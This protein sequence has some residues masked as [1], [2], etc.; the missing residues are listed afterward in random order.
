VK[1]VAKAEHPKDDVQEDEG[2]DNDSDSQIQTSS[3]LS[4]TRSSS[5]SVKQPQVEPGWTAA[6]SKREKKT[7]EK[8]I[9]T[10][11]S[12]TEE[13]VATS[14]PTPV[15]VST[16]VDV[17]PTKPSTTV[18]VD[19][20]K[21]GAVIGPKGATMKHIEEVSGC[22][23]RTIDRDPDV[24]AK[25]A[26]IH[27]EGPD[28]ESVREACRLVTE[29]C[30]KGYSVKLQG[31]DFI[32]AF[33]EVNS[34]N[35]PDLVGSGGV[36]VKALRDGCGVI[37]NLPA[38]KKLAS[39]VEKM[40]KVVIAGPKANVATAQ[41]AINDIMTK[42][43]SAVTHPGFTHREFSVEDWQ[44]ARF[45]GKAGSNIRHIQGDSK[46]RVYIPRDNNDSVKK[47]LVVG[48][49]KQ[50]SIASKHVIGILENIKEQANRV[51]SE[52]AFASSHRASKAE[53]DDEPHE[54]WMDEYLYKR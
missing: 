46:A 25:S 38:Q 9:D 29:L 42:Y 43:Y 39:G 34:R 53:D 21:I 1:S 27:V 11:P 20:K 3:S 16:E 54:E 17:G 44:I 37:V 51:S 5:K 22:K 24:Q 14:V 15:S 6:T 45:C 2:D 13:D 18:T 30:S 50:V 52:E 41:A 7:K 26:Q 40:V 32:E 47:V 36:V 23:L 48:T 19:P 49:S 4:Q 35:I 8:A 28:V 31:G 12:S 33:V 10:A